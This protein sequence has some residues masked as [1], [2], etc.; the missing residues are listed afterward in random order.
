MRERLEKKRRELGRKMR[1]R[2]LFWSFIICTLIIVG[3]FMH[4]GFNSDFT[5]LTEDITSKVAPEVLPTFRR[6]TTIM[7]MGVDVRK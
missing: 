4:M 1:N 2:K 6:P 7:L 3:S 5:R